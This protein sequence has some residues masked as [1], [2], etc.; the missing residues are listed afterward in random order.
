MGCHH[1]GHPYSEVAGGALYF[2]NAIKESDYE[3]DF[4]M[5]VRRTWAYY[6]LWPAEL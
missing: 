3:E 2:G 5:P 6:C 4:N 1:Q